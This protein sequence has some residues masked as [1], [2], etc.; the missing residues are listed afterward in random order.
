[1]M[2]KKHKHVYVNV[3]TFKNKNSFTIFIANR[4]QIQDSLPFF[5]KLLNNNSIPPTYCIQN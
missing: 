2:K 3:V 1:M 5:K 4:M